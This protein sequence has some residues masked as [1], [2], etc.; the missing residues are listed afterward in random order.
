MIKC[1]ENDKALAK[2]LSTTVPALSQALR[3]VLKLAY[4]KPLDRSIRVQKVTIDDLPPL[5]PQKNE[6][7]SLTLTTIVSRGL[8]RS[9]FVDLDGDSPDR[10]VMFVFLHYAS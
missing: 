2:Q 9:P 5:S 8:Q 4:E 1:I 3:H 7:V 6:P 10:Y